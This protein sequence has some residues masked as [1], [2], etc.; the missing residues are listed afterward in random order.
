MR[1]KP[2]WDWFQALG[3]RMSNRAVR[4]A[5]AVMLSGLLLWIGGTVC[6]AADAAPDASS[7][8]AAA[9]PLYGSVAGAGQVMLPPPSKIGPV[10]VLP[11]APGIEML[12]V[13]G[14]NVAVQSGPDGTLVV[15]PG[16]AQSAAAVLAA[17]RQIS[18]EPIHYLI[19]TDADSELIGANAAVAAAGHSV[20]VQDVFIAGQRRGFTNLV[21]LPGANGGGGAPIIARQ[22]VL[23]EMALQTEANYSSAAYPTDTFTRP[24]FNLFINEPIAVVRLPG[25]HNDADAAVRFERSN[26]VVTGEIFDPTRFP[27]IDLA[28]G[29]SVQGEIDALNLVIN[30]LVFAH[31]PVLGDDPGTLVIPVHGPL[32]TLDDLVSYRDM[33]ATVAMRV[34]YYMDRGRSYQQIVAAD[35]AQGF[36]TRYGSDTGSWTTADFVQAVYKSLTAERRSRH[37]QRG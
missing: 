11:V 37:G 15:D 34:Q 7:A 14:V 28:H 2:A 27:I 24:E 31:T 3:E 33:V 35:P 5:S 23:S 26:V 1:R 36:H 13:G 25:S 18:S 8:P 10:D 29:G 6:R 22:N 30:A 12:T 9:A 20:A 4:T 32:S 16:P 17:I 19:D 21:T